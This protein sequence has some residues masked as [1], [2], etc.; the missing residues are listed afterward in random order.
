[1][2]AEQ[3]ILEAYRQAAEIRR[4]AARAVRKAQEESR[5]LGVPNVYSRN[6]RLYY[7]SP[8]PIEQEDDTQ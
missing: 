7:D 1:M 3:Q 2:T 8:E 4:I 6:G 5:R